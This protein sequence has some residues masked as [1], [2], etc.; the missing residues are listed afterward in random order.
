MAQ[1]L[2]D[3]R[4]KI[5]SIDNQVHDLLMDR[6][7]LVSSVAAAK[8]KEGLQI[9]QP[10]REARMI[11]RLLARHKGP[12]PQAT[13]VRIWRE[14]VG[15]VSLLQTGLNVVVSGT[16]TQSDHWD[17][18]KNYFGSAVPMRKINN[19]SATVSAVSEGDAS[20]GVVP[21]P[22]LESPDPWWVHL[23]DQQNEPVSI[24]CAL[25]Y[26]AEKEST[27]K[28]SQK[29]LIVSKIDFMPS[30]DDV[31]FVGLR[32]S[33][34]VSRTK[35]STAFSKAGFDM[36]NMYN[37]RNTEKGVYLYLVEVRGYLACRQPYTEFQKIADQLDGLCLLMESFGG[38]PVIPELK[39]PQI[40]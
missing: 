28:P 7:S 35:I 26:G 32:L 5:D 14:L 13:I 17:M 15:S 24:I 2:G 18:A 12:L 37:A 33:G 16:H 31:S 38:Y 30:D 9:V 25:P 34:D 4:K 36:L 21:W 20:F 1:E 11:R 3:I 27:S 19:D 40:G 10:A 23:F 29:A 8:R 22:E 6:A 39:T